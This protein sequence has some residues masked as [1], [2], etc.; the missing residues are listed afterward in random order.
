MEQEEIKYFPQVGDSRDVIEQKARARK[1]AEESMIKAS[2]RTAEDIRSAAKIG[3]QKGPKEGEII[4]H[5]EYG[6]LVRRGGNARGL[7]VG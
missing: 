7:V 2:A 4:N 1:A 5:P 6:R 3:S